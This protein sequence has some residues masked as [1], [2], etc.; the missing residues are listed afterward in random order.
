MFAA[1]SA[2]EFDVFAIDNIEEL[3]DDSYFLVDQL[4]IAI[5]VL[6]CPNKLQYK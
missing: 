3:F 6:Y 1:A 4:V 2:S 5:F